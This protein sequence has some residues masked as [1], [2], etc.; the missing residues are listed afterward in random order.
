MDYYDILG[1]SPDASVDDIKKAYRAKAKETHP[2]INKDDPEAE[3]KFKRIVEAYETLS[4]QQKREAYDMQRSGFP[5]RFPDLDGFGSFFGAGGPF[6]YRRPQPKQPP[7]MEPRRGSD[8]RA[9][10]TISLFESIAGTTISG[11]AKFNGACRSCGGLGGHDFSNKCSLC[12]GTGIQQARNGNMIVRTP[13]SACSG[14]GF[15]YTQVCTTCSGERIQWY[16]NEYSLDIEP[17]F[18]GGDLIVSGKGEPGSFGGP[19]GN[20]HVSV[21]VKFPDIDLSEATEEEIAVLKKYLS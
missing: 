4:D 16:E 6:G 12:N 20:L 7:G 18:M 13:C 3:D 5:F 21:S 15:S 10:R 19:D 11:V 9:R 8:V 1:V 2:D 17:G 14:S